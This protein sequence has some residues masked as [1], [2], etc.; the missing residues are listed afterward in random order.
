MS[1]V[2]ELREERARATPAAFTQAAVAR[3]LGVAESTLRAWETGASVP[4][5]RHARA[6]A[7]DLGVSVE[8]LELGRESA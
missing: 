8:D 7:R 4:R 6:L 2:R 5:K 1:R 3:R